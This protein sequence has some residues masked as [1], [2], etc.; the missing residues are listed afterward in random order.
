MK[1]AKFPEELIGM[2]VE[3]IQATNP[4][5]KGIIGRIDD[6]TKETIVV[7]GKVLLKRAIIIK[8]ANGKLVEGK[9][10]AKRPE[11]RIKGK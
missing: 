8:L 9:D 11:E 2:E 1:K 5:L 3:V 10:L 7:N 4:S 6:E